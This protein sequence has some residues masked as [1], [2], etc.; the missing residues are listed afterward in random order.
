MKR[1]FIHLLNKKESFDLR[2]FHSLHTIKVKYE[3]KNCIWLLEWYDIPSSNLGCH[4]VI[5]E[6]RV[7][8]DE[9]LSKLTLVYLQ[10]NPVQV[11]YQIWTTC[12]YRK[13]NLSHFSF[14]RRTT[15]L[16]MLHLGH[17]SSNHRSSPVSLCSR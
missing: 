7:V 11:N 13:T 15:L 17:R 2:K 6:P 16:A 12:I 4:L 9:C 1:K 3:F 5:D 8:D 14:C 10:W